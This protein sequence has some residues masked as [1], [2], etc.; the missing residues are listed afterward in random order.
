MKK[1]FAWILTLVLLLSG[2]CTVA[3]A[4]VTGGWEIRTTASAMLKD[5][6]ARKALE[7]G[8]E[9]YTGYEVK[10]L[11]LLGTQVVAGTNY[12][13]LGYGSTVTLTPKNNLCLAYVYEDLAGK[14]EITKIKTIHL[15][16][17]PAGGWKL[18]QKKSALKVD[19]KVTKALKKATAGLAG[20][21]YKA[22]LVVA[23]DKT[24]TA[25]CVL[26]RK[27][28]SDAEGTTGLCLAY[29]AKKDGQYRLSRV[30][31]IKVAR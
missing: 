2:V 11:A 20:A 1:M 18:A 23:R 21:S 14:C 25:F 12:C 4:A 26:C 5:A 17:K 27:K 8:M 16:E 9:E 7:K 10:P 24:D 13:I 15:K 6:Q 31:D 22:L 29:L 19:S 28:L 30:E 3:S